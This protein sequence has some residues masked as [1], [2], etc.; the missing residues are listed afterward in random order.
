MYNRAC[1]CT[2]LHV[3]LGRTLIWGIG[4]KDLEVLP[5]LLGSRLDV[6]ELIPPHVGRGVGDI[7]LPHR[8]A[9]SIGGLPI[10]AA[11]G[12]LE[13]PSSQIGAALMLAKRQAN[14]GSY[15]GGVWKV[16]VEVDGLH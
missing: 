4:F 12:T 7:A 8:E 10:V 11:S 14:L 6:Q 2:R 5:L 15:R 3:V 9:A 13:W 1:H 16:E